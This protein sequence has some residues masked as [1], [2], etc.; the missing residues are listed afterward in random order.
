[1]CGDPCHRQRAALLEREWRWLAGD[2]PG[3]RVGVA[4]QGRT[5]HPK[6]RRVA[7]MQMCHAGIDHDACHVGSRRTGLPRILSKH[8]ENIAKVEADSPDA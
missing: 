7:R 4:R 6:D 1:M 2:K 3:I 5:S 8:I